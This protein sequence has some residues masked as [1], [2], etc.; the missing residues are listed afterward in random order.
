MKRYSVLLGLVLMVFVMSACQE[1]DTIIVPDHFKAFTDQWDHEG[2]KRL[3]NLEE[4]PVYRVYEEIPGT[5]TVI[6]SVEAYEEPM[7]IQVTLNAKMVLEVE[8]L[9][10]NETDDYGGDY[11]VERWFLDRLLV[12]TQKPLVTVRRKKD[13]ENEVIAI[14]G[15]TITSD[16]LV[17]AVNKSIEIREAYENENN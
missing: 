12:K 17:M 7:L 15:A 9:Y 5:L 3:Y 14:T 1:K 10:E 6:Q 4:E 2:H 13:E 16:S 8:V 11:V